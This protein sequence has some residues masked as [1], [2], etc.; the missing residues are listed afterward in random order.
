MTMTTIFLTVADLERTRLS[1]G[2]WELIDG[3]L[4]EMS[5]AGRRHTR[6]IV[7]LI[8]RLA[9]FVIPRRLGEVLAPDSGVVLSEN[10]LVIRVPDAGFIRADRLAR[11]ADEAGFYRVVPDLVV[12]VVSPSDRASEVIAKALLWLDAGA[13]V[14]WSVDTSSET[15][16]L[17]K[18]GQLPRVLTSADTL[19]GDEM[20]PGF[21]LP[22]RDIFAV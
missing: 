5:P 11:D 6:I 9:A 15:V 7:A 14:V 1:E 3:E 22:V 2:L 21:E 4:V 18:Q 17:F 20:L 10:P 13:T 8:Y 12:E 19:A 16:T